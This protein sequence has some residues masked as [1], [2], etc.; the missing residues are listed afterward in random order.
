ME[1][2]EDTADKCYGVAKVEN[3]PRNLDKFLGRGSATMVER[4][5]ID[6]NATHILADKASQA[7]RDS[8]E[9]D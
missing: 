1:P 3:W 4:E 7:G 5:K 2:N 9:E 8:K 6:V